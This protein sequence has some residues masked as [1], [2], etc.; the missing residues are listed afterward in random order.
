MSASKHAA[1]VLRGYVL[2][3][4][5]QAKLGKLRDHLLLMSHVVFAATQE[6]QDVPLQIRRSDLAQLFEDFGLRVDE[7]LMA[8]PWSGQCLQSPSR[9][10]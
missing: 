8:L 1:P 5:Q 7:I 9:Q 10:Q 6:E 3:E 2:S 4:D